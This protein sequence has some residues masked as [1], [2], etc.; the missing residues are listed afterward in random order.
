VVFRAEKINWLAQ[1]PLHHQPGLR[2]TYSIGTDVLGRLIE[3]ISGMALD[4]FFKQHIFEPLGMVDTDFYVPPEKLDRLATLYTS[5]PGW[6]T[7]GYPLPGSILRS[8]FHKGG[9]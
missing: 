6:K 2:Y 3:F 7:R 8:A 1:Y 5:T 9:R 4:E